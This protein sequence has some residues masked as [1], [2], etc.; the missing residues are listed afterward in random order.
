MTPTF[1]HYTSPFKPPRQTAVLVVCHIWRDSVMAMV[2]ILLPRGSTPRHATNSPKPAEYR[3]ILDSP[4]G[5]S[6]TLYYEPLGGE[7]ND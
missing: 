6:E 4:A 7:S 2:S 5:R 1:F 3:G